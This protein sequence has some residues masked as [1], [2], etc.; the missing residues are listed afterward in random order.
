MTTSRNIITL[1][2]FLVPND[3]TLV[4]LVLNSVFGKGK[5]FAPK[6][7]FICIFNEVAIPLFYTSEVSVTLM[8][9]KKSGFLT[10]LQ[11]P[12]YVLARRSVIKKM[13][14]HFPIVCHLAPLCNVGIITYNYYFK[15]TSSTYLVSLLPPFHY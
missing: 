3:H 11:P 9:Y 10:S 5:F 1:S 14:M 15:D 12:G 7:V 6:I 13:N 4:I 2:Y 8:C